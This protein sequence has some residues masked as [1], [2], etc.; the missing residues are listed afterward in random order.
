MKKILFEIAILFLISSCTY[1]ISSPMREKART[2]VPF[3]SIKE[4]VDKYK[5]SI[6]ILGGII[7]STKNTEEG[8]IIEAVHSE[9]DAFG[10]II[11]PDRSAGRF[12]AIYRGYLDPLIYKKGRE[13]T[14]AGEL[15]GSR[16]KSIG[17]IEYKY[18]L[19]EI[20]EIYL[21]REVRGYFYPPPPYPYP[22]YWYRYPYW[23]YDPWWYGPHYPPPPYP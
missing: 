19:F 17:E 10:N 3:S 11:D 22:P 16:K 14:I 15:I 1:V 4:N 18:P 23:W 7:V 13:I 6:F 12:M 2:D 5:G 8:S 20:K 21:W 9:V